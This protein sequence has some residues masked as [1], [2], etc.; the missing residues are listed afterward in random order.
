MPLT[1]T[2]PELFKIHPIHLCHTFNLTDVFYKPRI[3]LFIETKLQLKG[4][5]SESRIFHYI[6]IFFV[7]IGLRDFNTNYPKHYC[8]TLLLNVRQRM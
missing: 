8:K 2:I 4:L 6:I 3:F 1:L 7:N 5:D